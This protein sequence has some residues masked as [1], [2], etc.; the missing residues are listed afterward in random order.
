MQHDSQ[1]SLLAHNLATPYLGCEP[2]VRVVTM[3]FN[4]EPCKKSNGR[5]QHFVGEDGL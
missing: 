2:K 4:V 1:A 5:I 3:D